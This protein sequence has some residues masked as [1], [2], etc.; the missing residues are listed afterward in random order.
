MPGIRVISPGFLTTIQDL[1][2][3]GYAHLGI[4]ASGAADPVALRLGNMLV[5][6]PENAPA[7][8]MTLVG[9]VLEFD[10]SCTIALTGAD[11]SP[12]LDGE[13]IPLW[14]AVRV[15]PGKVLRCGAASKG[16]RSYLSAQGGI[17]V[18]K[19]FGSASTHLATGI[20]GFGGRSLKQG[21]CIRL[22]EG[23]VRGET[24]RRLDRSRLPEV[25]GVLRVTAGPQADLFGDSEF[26]SS[27]YRVSE[28]SDRMGLRLD[29]PPVSFDGDILTE[30]VSLGAVQITPSGCPII[31][32]VDH[33]TTGG[34]P[35]IANV[36][37]ADI[38][39]VGQ[40]R[41]RDEVYFEL[42]SLDQ[43]RKILVDQESLIRRAL[44]P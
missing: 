20:G 8:E 32:F 6:N 14:T 12:T 33:Q 15:E 9:A 7:L 41:P 31:L 28:D 25:S 19:K 24:L 30:G 5:G 22:T 2:R 35:K 44:R 23:M 11:M 21:D 17:D 36:I 3:Y 10:S 39:R 29:G 1:G 34:Y 38:G 37:S 40:L 43:A 27:R 13:D 42:V 16:A 26:Y 18:E 4:S